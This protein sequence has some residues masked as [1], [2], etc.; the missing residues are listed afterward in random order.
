VDA[1]NA[2][3]CGFLS[4]CIPASRSLSSTVE[5]TAASSCAYDLSIEKRTGLSSSFPKPGPP[6]HALTRIEAKTPFCSKV[7]CTAFET[8]ST[9]EC[10][11]KG[12]CTTRCWVAFFFDGPQL[13][14]LFPAFSHVRFEEKPG[15]NF[16]LGWLS[17]HHSRLWRSFP[18]SFVL[19]RRHSVSCC[20]VLQ[21]ARYGPQQRKQV[22]HLGMAA[23]LTR[24]GWV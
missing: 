17:S 1:R 7:E 24:S 14:R 8:S 15:V 10:C 9:T 20:C 22:V 13:F 6:Q 16:G 4:P 21:W 19:P 5:Y 23:T 12:S 11:I 18:A 3:T 2:A